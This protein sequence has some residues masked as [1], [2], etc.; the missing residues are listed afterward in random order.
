MTEHIDNIRLNGDLRYRFDYL[1]KFVNFSQNDIAALNTLAT[2]VLPRVPVIV[3][4]VYRKLFQFDVTKNFFVLRNDGFDGKLKDE[5]SLTLESAQMTYRKDMLSGYLKR[6]FLQQEWT[7]DFL[8]YLSRVGR[9]HTNKMGAASINVDFIHINATLSYI[10]T[11]L[12]EVVWNAE[13]LDSKT[14]KEMLMA[15]NKVF[16]IQND[17]F[18]LHYLEPAK[19]DEPPRHRK[20]TDKCACS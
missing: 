13:T 16:R 10:E 1:S 4:A 20:R 11:L 3:D 14:K 12:I 2:T 19:E 7:D 6:L 5:Q 15:L 8:Q 17:F 18:L 9:M